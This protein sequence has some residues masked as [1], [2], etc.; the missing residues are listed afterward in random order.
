MG[1]KSKRTVRLAL[2]VQEQGTEKWETRVENLVAKVTY[3][4]GGEAVIAGR[5]AGENST[6]VRVRA[7]A[8][9]GISTEWRLKDP[10]TG[11]VFN[12]KSIAPYGR[13]YVDLTCR[14]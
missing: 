13:A 3:L 4:R 11:E 5:I 12:I 2:N 6:V 8:V 7:A 10:N 9:T 14:S 1:Q